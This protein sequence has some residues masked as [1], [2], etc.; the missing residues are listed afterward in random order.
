L[1]EVLPEV[2]DPELLWNSILLIRN[3][4]VLKCAPGL[5]QALQDFDNPPRLN[6]LNG[7]LFLHSQDQQW[8]FKAGGE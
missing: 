2:I 6:V 4:T 5:S 7:N 3:M 1:P 8:F